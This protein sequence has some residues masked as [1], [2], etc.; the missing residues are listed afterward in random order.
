MALFWMKNGL[1]FR[2]VELV[3]NVSKSFI[4]RD[5]QHTIPIL[6]T[7]LNEI[8]LPV[9]PVPGLLGAIGSVDCTIHIRNRVNPGQ[10][11]LW[12]GD[13]KCH[14][15]SAQLV[16][17]LQGVPIKV[18]IGLGHN[19]DSAMFTASNIG[20]WLQQNEV[21]LFADGIYRHSNLITPRAPTNDVE[22]LTLQKQY[23]Y[24][25]CVETVFSQVK[26]WLITKFPFRQSIFFQEI[27]LMVVYELVAICLKENPL[28]QMTWY[29]EEN[30]D[31]INYQL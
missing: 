13:K 7:Q 15:L 9:E 4:S 30:Q 17:D 1:H 24:R 29:F 5:L 20:D 19:N 16:C 11:L 31:L 2:L 25:S 22:Q 21:N 8:N 23:T 14:F 26:T 6:Y 18:D 12:R 27:V 10:S 3:F 28:R